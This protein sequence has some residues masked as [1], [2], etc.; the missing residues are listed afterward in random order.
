MII[1]KGKILKYGSQ[2]IPVAKHT[3]MKAQT[4]WRYSST[5]SSAKSLLKF[6][7]KTVVVIAI[8]IEFAS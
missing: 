8:L 3:A 2:V 4:Q 1:R 6:Q 5:L 7:Q